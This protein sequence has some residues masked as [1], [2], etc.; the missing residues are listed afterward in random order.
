[1]VAVAAA[2]AGAAAV[3][4]I[5]AGLCEIL[6]VLLS[7]GEV[8]F[9]RAVESD[10]WEETLEDQVALG[11]PG[12]YLMPLGFTL[13]ATAAAADK[14][15]L[16]MASGPW[17]ALG[18]DHHQQQQEWCALLPVQQ[19]EACA[20]AGAA[21]AA[22]GE[23]DSCSVPLAEGRQ[24]QGLVWLSSSRLLLLAAPYPDPDLEGGC[25]TVL[26][27]VAVEIPAGGFSTSRPQAAAVTSCYAGALVLTGRPHPAGGAVL[28]LQDGQLL[29]YSCYNSQLIPLGTAA[30]FPAACRTLLV[31]PDAP[32][33]AAAA[34]AAAAAAV[35]TAATATLTTSGSVPD[36]QQRPVHAAAA[37]AAA[38]AGS[39]AVGLT[40][41]GQLYWGSWC[42]ADNVC[43]AAVR[44][45]GAG[46]PALLFVTRQALLYV[47]MVAQL[48]SYCH[49]LVSAAAAAAAAAVDGQDGG[50][51][52]MASRQSC[53]ISC[54]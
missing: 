52:V 26:V 34:T 40:A 50:G 25:G 7:D 43:S 44:G 15:F 5:A 6:A 47:V 29:Y 8:V 39:P 37:A 49:V 21:A 1:M 41:G 35:P 45:G 14:N 30:S 28:Q 51:D 23:Y 38:A 32:L 12:H 17:T 46:G 4:V 18:K 9:F 33:P 36:A 22:A 24:V 31:L 48:P 13:P 10:L 3:D 11:G 27:E 54:C 53:C 16:S 2:A 20:A 19:H 42:I